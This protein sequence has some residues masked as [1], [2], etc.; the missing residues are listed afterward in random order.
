MMFIPFIFIL[1]WSFLNYAELKKGKLNSQT[2]KLTMIAAIILLI[3]IFIIIQLLT[4]NILIIIFDLLKLGLGPR[5]II[6]PI[7]WIILMIYLPK[8]SLEKLNEYAIR[9]DKS[10]QN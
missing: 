6:Q 4:D 9:F 7:I 3:I 5:V 8:W 10:R 2:L 1:V